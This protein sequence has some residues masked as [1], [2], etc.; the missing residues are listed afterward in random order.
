MAT[1][2]RQMAPGAKCAIVDCLVGFSFNCAIV[3]VITVSRYI[4]T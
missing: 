3:V 1:V 2:T 4:L